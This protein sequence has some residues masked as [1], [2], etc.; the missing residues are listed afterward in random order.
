M[1]QAGKMGRAGQQSLTMK[2][3]NTEYF[4]HCIARA[5]VGVSRD[6]GKSQDDDD[7]LAPGCSQELLTHQGQEQ[8]LPE[9]FQQQRKRFPDISAHKQGSEISTRPNT[10]WLLTG[11]LLWPSTLRAL[12]CREGC[13]QA[14]D[15]PESAGNLLQTT[16]TGNIWL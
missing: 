6:L 10:R 13:S 2:S 4:S 16:A 5:T 15:L 8:P 11:G 12:F 3:E 14:P 7:E 1:F 9:G